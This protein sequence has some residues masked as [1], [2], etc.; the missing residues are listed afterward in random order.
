MSHALLHLPT[1]HSY[2]ETI[3]AFTTKEAHPGC[4]SQ[5]LGPKQ[6]PTSA[7]FCF[8]LLPSPMDNKIAFPAKVAI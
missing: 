4:L 6:T 3:R 2:T 8:R 7:E 5:S 1:G